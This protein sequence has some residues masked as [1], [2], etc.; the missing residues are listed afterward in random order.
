MNEYELGLFVSGHLPAFEYDVSVLHDAT[1]CWLVCS[2]RR[3]R[4]SSDGR[5]N[6]PYDFDTIP[7]TVSSHLR[8][9]LLQKG[10]RP[11]SPTD[12]HHFLSFQK[13]IGDMQYHHFDSEN[14]F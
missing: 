5:Q 12:Y 13:P 11:Q 8:D 7:D 9:T 6:L 3:P 1:V 4:Q 2:Q 14:F 10:I